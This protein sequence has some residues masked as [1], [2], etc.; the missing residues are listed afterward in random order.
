MN[1]DKTIFSSS[2]VHRRPKIFFGES[3]STPRAK[4]SRS[5]TGAGE[6]RVSLLHNARNSV[7]KFR[8]RRPANVQKEGRLDQFELH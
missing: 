8:C 1:A 7:R 6:A 2:A 3:T 4:A 5:A